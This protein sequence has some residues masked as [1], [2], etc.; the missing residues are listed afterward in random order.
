MGYNPDI[1]MLSLLSDESREKR[2]VSA[3]KQLSYL[4]GIFLAYEDKN[5]H[6]EDLL[7]NLQTQL[8]K[9]DNDFFEITRENNHLRR[10]LESKTQ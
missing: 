6:L 1:E 5:K 8:R 7:K 10:E 2:I 4:D 3:I 9:T